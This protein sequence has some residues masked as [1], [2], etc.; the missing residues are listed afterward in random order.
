MFVILK[1]KTNVKTKIVK[2]VYII[3][4]FLLIYNSF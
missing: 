2:K 1:I 4:S 3:I